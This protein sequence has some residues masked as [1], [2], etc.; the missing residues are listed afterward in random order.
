MYSFIKK[1]KVILGTDR[2]RF[3]G[4]LEKELRRVAV[5]GGSGGSLIRDAFDQG[6]DLLLTGDVGHHE[7]L[8]AKTLGLAVVDGGHFLTERLGLKK[9]TAFFQDTIREREWV[10]DIVFL[11]DEADP[12]SWV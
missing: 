2:L 8:E 10:V 9:F 3:T 12:L 6:A 1:V 11:E 4:G 7:A 5:V